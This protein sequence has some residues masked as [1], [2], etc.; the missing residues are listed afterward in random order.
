MLTG[1]RPESAAIVAKEL[2]LDEY[3]AGLLPEGKAAELESL[4]PRPVR[5]FC[6]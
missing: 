3:R 6:R 5:T 4:G 1:D 2:H